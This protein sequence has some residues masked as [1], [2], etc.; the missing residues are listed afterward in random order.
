MA[1][2]FGASRF[3]A[4][5]LESAQA[6]TGLGTLWLLL[7]AC[8]GTAGWLGLVERG[9]H[10]RRLGLAAVAVGALHGAVFGAGTA[11]EPWPGGI[12]ELVGA[13]PYALPGLAAWLALAGVAWLGRPRAP[14]RRAV[15]GLADVVLLLTAVHLAAGVE[16]G[17]RVPILGAIACLLVYTLRQFTRRRRQSPEHPMGGRSPGSPALNSP[18]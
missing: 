18:P 7:A 17:E 14:R 5:D 2:C 8:A 9:I 13:R 4:R 1:V 10:V 16:P 15:S 12:R 11:G 6:W 3:A